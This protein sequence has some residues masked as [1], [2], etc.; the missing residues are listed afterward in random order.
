MDVLLEW[1]GDSELHIWDSAASD[2]TPCARFTFAVSALPIHVLVFVYVLFGVSLVQPAQT[3]HR[4]RPFMAA[5]AAFTSLFAI[6]V[7]LS[8]ADDV[9]DMPAAARGC[10]AMCHALSWLAGAVVLL[11]DFSTRT[12]R[13]FIFALLLF[14]A[15]LAF[16]IQSHV[17]RWRAGATQWQYG[18]WWGYGLGLLLVQATLLLE[19]AW[20]RRRARRAAGSEQEP[21]LG[22]INADSPTMPAEPSGHGSW[23]ARASLCSRLT[24][25]WIWPLLKKALTVG[26]VVAADLP[27]VCTSFLCAALSSASL[28]L[29]LALHMQ[30]YLSPPRHS[31]L[32]GALT[33]L[34]FCPP[35]HHAATA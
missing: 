33:P 24:F 15:A 35:S 3:H 14:D 10:G 23:E 31:I 25:F 4:L 20:A 1:C 32:R 17:R 9:G 16:L 22:A 19:D 8:D 29:A 34:C 11:V 13:F 21:L 5:L 28:G 7:L 26:K 18:A 12:R 2:L 27:E 30:L 6:V